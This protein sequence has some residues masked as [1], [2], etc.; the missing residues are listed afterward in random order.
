MLPHFCSLH[1]ISWFIQ[2]V[3][4]M[5]DTNNTCTFDSFNWS[6]TWQIQTTLAHLIHSIGQSHG[7]YK[8]HLH[9]QHNHNSVKHLLTVF[10]A[11]DNTTSCLTMLC[12]WNMGFFNPLFW[13]EYQSSWEV[14]MYQ[15]WMAIEALALKVIFRSFAN[16]SWVS[17]RRVTDRERER[18]LLFSLRSHVLCL[19]TLLWTLDP[20]VHPSL[21]WLIL[22][23]LLAVG[24]LCPTCHCLHRLFWGE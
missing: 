21:V 24:Q 16:A 12:K 14:M 1:S 8:Q 15:T 23:W 22:S 5:A 7:R 4:H 11:Q 18:E 10:F 9:T 6:V 3:S 19:S 17:Q 2:L 20:A 13:I